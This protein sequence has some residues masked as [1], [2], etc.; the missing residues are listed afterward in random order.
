MSC[1]L[2]AMLYE[3]L[4]YIACKQIYSKLIRTSM[5]NMMCHTGRNLSLCY[6]HKD[7]Y[8]ASVSLCLCR[9]PYSSASRNHPRS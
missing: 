6:S 1:I 5:H 3:I 9:A 2:R 8:A 4:N 7:K